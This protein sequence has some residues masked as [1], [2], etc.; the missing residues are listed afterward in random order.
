MSE[1]RLYIKA[2]TNYNANPPASYKRDADYWEQDMS[3][4]LFYMSGNVGIGY[5]MP[6]GKFTIDGTVGIG[7]NTPMSSLDVNGN[8]NYETSNGLIKITPTG[9]RTSNRASMLLESKTNQPSE[10][11]LFHKEDS[12]R[13]GWQISARG[14]TQ[15]RNLHIYSATNFNYTHTLSITHDLGNVGIGTSNPQCKLHVNDTGAIIIPTGTTVQQPVNT[16]AGMMRYNT[17]SSQ[18]QFYNGLS[19]MNILLTNNLSASGGNTT[20]DVSGYR[21][22]TFTSSGTLYVLNSGGYAEVLVVGGGGGGGWD[23]GGG[24]GAGGLIY[25]SSMFIPPGALTVTVGS[26]GPGATV[27]NAAPSGQNGGNSS[28]NGIV[29]L[30][31]GG[32]G[33]YV[34]GS[35][36][37]GGSGGGAS[38]YTAPGQPA[39]GTLGQGNRGGYANSGN[40]TAN[41]GGGGGGAGGVGSN[42]I[43]NNTS[44]VEG[45]IGLAYNISGTSVIY[46]KG[47]RGAG[48]QWTGGAVGAANT[49]NGGD[50]GGITSGVN[51]GLAGGSGVVIIR[52]LL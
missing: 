49:G 33:N 44:F 20:T 40:T 35:G 21:I 18:L 27:A 23:V 28:F 51:N 16:F 36:A 48:D 24:G 37:T 19:W 50:G 47:G 6:Y 31:G 26:G 4:N 7:T 12:D 3:N 10:I 34:S 38:G 29:A 45:G 13:Y 41:T 43:Q 15:N 11:D 14:F 46:A 17:T 9:W 52:Y 25:V 39:V 1:P 22:H 2:K 32:G 42:S 5:P 30:G 8:S